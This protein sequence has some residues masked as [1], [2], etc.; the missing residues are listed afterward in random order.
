MIVYSRRWVNGL[1]VGTLLTA[2]VS[3]ASDG[4]W[5]LAALLVAICAGWLFFTW[6]RRHS[7]DD[8]LR[9]GRRK[10]NDG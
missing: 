1:G 5:G 4:L 2:A 9:I 6:L 7:D 8:V 10:P 3:A